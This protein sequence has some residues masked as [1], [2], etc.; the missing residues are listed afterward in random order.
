M[1]MPESKSPTIESLP[2]SIVTCICG[3]TESTD[4]LQLRASSSKLLSYFV[5]TSSSCSSS[6]SAGSDDHAVNVTSGHDGTMDI[7]ETEAD[8]IWRNALVRDFGFDLS[9]TGT[10]TATTLHY[11]QTLGIRIEPEE[12]EVGV[13]AP[14]RTSIFGYDFS[15]DGSVFTANNAF[16]SWKHWSKASKVFHKRQANDLMVDEGGMSMSEDDDDKN[17]YINGPYFLRA[18]LVWR[19][20]DQWC[21]SDESGTFGEKLLLTFESGVRRSQGRFPPQTNWK[22]VHALEA[23]FAFC[24]GQRWLLEEHVLQNH[25]GSSSVLEISLDG[26]FRNKLRLALFGGYEVYDHENFMRLVG[27]Y[28]ATRDFRALPR[29]E[30]ARAQGNFGSIPNSFVMISCNYSRNAFKSIVVCIKNG[31]MF[32]MCPNANAMIPVASDIGDQIDIG[33]LWMEEYARRLE[34]SLVRVRLNR[35]NVEILS[36]FPSALSPLASTR[37]TRGIEIV[38]SSV[39]APEAGILTYSLSIRI[40]TEG[41]D[42]YLTAEQRG[43]ETCQLHTRH[44]K[45]HDSMEDSTDEVEGAGVVGRYPLLREGGY[46]DDS[47]SGNGMV[48]EGEEV[49][50]TFQYQS[51]ANLIDGTFEGRVCFVPG[52]LNKPSGSRFYADVGKFNLE[53]MASINY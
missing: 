39:G 13:G 19:K 1:E 32:T 46:R 21:R 10:A 26:N 23:V 16:Q 44:W 4:L 11:L 25:D 33:L 53:M 48:V 37:V 36:S 14:R 5:N 51:C 15:E 30:A 35:N 12:V 40:L 49:S 24:E 45:I 41:E 27:P 47:D 9:T 28:D 17:I 29:G 34:N 43:F 2:S 6:S 20:I 52:E 3:F 18:A 31:K 22:A 50:G 8:I 38:A 42:G 7:E